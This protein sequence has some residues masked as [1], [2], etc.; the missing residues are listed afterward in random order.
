MS[1]CGD[2]RRLVARRDAASGDEQAPADAAWDRAL[3]HYDQCEACRD[4]ALS[5]DP[6]LV[7]RRLPAP[8]ARQADVDSMKIAVAALRGAKRIEPAASRPPWFWRSAAAAIVAATLGA[9]TLL[10]IQTHST[11]VNAPAV[12]VAAVDAAAVDAAATI[13]I[14]ARD[15]DDLTAFDTTMPVEF[16]SVEAGQATAGDPL[17]PL[18]ASMPLI[19]T[20]DE[21]LG[22]V[23]QLVDG[24]LAVVIVG[25][26]ADGDFDV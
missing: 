21:S 17:A 4:E 15:S 13:E 24:D 2:W 11:A 9:V 25:A 26:P 16:A 5:A 20:D 8:T 18:L 6:T 19:D 10:S 7:F 3:E 14:M 1:C 12:D 23:I 22:E